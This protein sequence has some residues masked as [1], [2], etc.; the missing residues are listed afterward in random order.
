[1]GQRKII[2]LLSGEIGTGKSSLSVKLRDRFNF[3]ILK[4]R[5]SIKSLGNKKLKGKTPDRDFYQKFGESLDKNSGGKWVLESFMKEFSNEFGEK[6]RFI[7]DSVRIQ[8][9][10]D[11][12]RKAYSYSVFHLH[13]IA[14]SEI[15]KARC[16]KRE[17]FATFSPEEAIIKYET[18]KS[19]TTE[20]NV[21][22][23]KSDADLI[24]DTERCTEEDV[25]I[26]VASFF[27]LLAPTKNELVDVIVGG[28]FGSEGKGNIA[29]HIAPE[30]DCLVR[31]GGPNAGHTVY[32][33]P[34]NHVFNLLPSGTWRNQNAKIVLGP[35]MVLNEEKLLNEIRE[36][37]VEDEF[38]RRLFIDE[39]AIVICQSDI[40]REKE[41]MDKIGST[42]QGVGFATANN[43][44]ARLQ[45][46]TK[47]KAKNFNKLKPFIGSTSE[48]LECEFRNNKKVLL[49]GTQGSGLSLHHGLYP[50]VTS[51]DTNVSGCL[52]EAGISPKRVRKI[53]M[54]TRT[55]P[56]RVGGASGE[57]ISNELSMKIIADRSGKDV[58]E[59]IKK[60]KTTTT[61]KDRRIAEFSWTMF[62]KACE[63]NSPTDIALTFTD[64]ISIQNSK[65][66]RYDQLTIETRQMIEE[67]E[68]CSGVKVSLIGIGFDYRAII[69]R[70]NWK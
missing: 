53:I 69:D 60:E 58:N 20:L 40:D 34:K 16:L 45:N 36:Y 64:Y 44:I 42:G 56:I 15:L 27:N 67:I 46:E 38:K 22:S 55:Y 61:K 10:I 18:S 32:E 41:I 49:E 2:L 9:Q 52:S 31:V 11:H 17:E 70:R 8:D 19:D 14:S 68:R 3:E 33:E 59:L 23:L 26:R 5:E 6:N 65:A 4:T 1:M 62:R 54:V 51:R 12:F 47:H 24:I 7:V 21:N 66:K 48:I 57:F 29:G 13:L 39:N 35:G 28:Q 37:N 25:F 63:I 30:Y 50:H 43:I